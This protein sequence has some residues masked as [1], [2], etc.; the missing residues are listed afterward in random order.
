M[1]DASERLRWVVDQVDPG[2]ADVVLEV[3][4][5]HGVAVT[6]L[7]DRLPDGHVTALDRSATMVAATRRRNAEHVEHGRV[8]VLEGSLGAVDL[9]DR[10]FDTV[11]AVNV[12]AFA[13]Q[14]TT[15]LGA[16]RRHLLPHGRLWLCF[17][18]PPSG[19]PATGAIERFQAALASEGF[20]VDEVRRHDLA[21]GTEMA[22][23]VAHPG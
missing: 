17:Q 14:P 19:G 9:G 2:P 7:A 13:R 8:E 1:S 20:V 15:T 4:C 6:L 16:V 23:V 12:I 10:R 11:L 3:G 21:D 18:G 5:G 22:A